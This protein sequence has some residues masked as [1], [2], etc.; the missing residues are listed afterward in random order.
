MENGAVWMQFLLPVGMIAIFYFLLIRP[1]Q[2]RQKE[3]MLMQSELQRGDKI[4]TI[5]GLH[6]TIDSVDSE[7]DVI[8]IKVASGAHMA[9]DRNAIRNVVEKANKDI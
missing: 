3:T 2:K 4:V 1:Q 8:T 7:N 9:F 5:G 6:G